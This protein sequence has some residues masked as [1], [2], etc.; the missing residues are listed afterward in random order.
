MAGEN[1]IELR[2]PT[3]ESICREC[4]VGMTR[5]RF[6]PKDTACVFHFRYG[7][8]HQGPNLFGNLSKY[9]TP[10]LLRCVAYWGHEWDPFFATA[11]WGLTREQLIKRAELLRDAWDICC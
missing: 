4:P 1:V 9:P 7:E 10:Q 11:L 8:F 5:C 6:S 3:V 2:I